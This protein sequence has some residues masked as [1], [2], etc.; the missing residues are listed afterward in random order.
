MSSSSGEQ[1]SIAI[2]IGCIAYLNE[3]FLYEKGLFRSSASLTD[4]RLLHTKMMQ[5]DVNKVRNETDPHVVT[6]LL[7]KTLKDM[8]PA[9]F[10]GVY[11]DI[12]ATVCSYPILYSYK[13]LS[14]TYIKCLLGIL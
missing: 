11:E 8:S 7:Q 13:T 3:R 4:I 10:A 5:G 9:A 12:L 2:A 14:L 1:Q 6:G